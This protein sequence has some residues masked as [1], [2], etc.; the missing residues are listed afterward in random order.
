M[1]HSP[2][3]TPALVGSCKAN[4]PLLRTWHQ[5]CIRLNPV[6]Q[7]ENNHSYSTTAAVFGFGLLW[8]AAATHMRDCFAKQEPIGEPAAWGSIPAADQ[9]CS[10]TEYQAVQQNASAS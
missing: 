10:A 3:A 1:T 9:A 8:M 5:P 2:L 4:S 6:V 7:N